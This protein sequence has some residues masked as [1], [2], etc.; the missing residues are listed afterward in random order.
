MGPAHRLVSLRRAPFSDAAG[1]LKYIDYRLLDNWCF[2]SFA[3]NIPVDDDLNDRH[4]LFTLKAEHF[5][6]GFHAL[7]VAGKM[8]AGPLD[9]HE[10][11]PALRKAFA[12]LPAAD[13]VTTDKDVVPCADSTG[14][15]SCLLYTS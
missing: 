12:E 10:I 8:P 7:K 13:L 14:D 6:K 3:E 15:K 4:L 5:S 11:G 2:S 1:G 9:D